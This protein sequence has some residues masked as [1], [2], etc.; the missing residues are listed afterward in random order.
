[1]GVAL[2]S[3]TSKATQEWLVDQNTDLVKGPSAQQ[4]GAV[5]NVTL[6]LNGYA[7]AIVEF[8]P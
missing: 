2:G 3:A 1:V 6:N 7:V 4:L 8:A 5:S